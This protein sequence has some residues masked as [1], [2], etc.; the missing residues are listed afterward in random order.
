MYGACVGNLTLRAA[1]RVTVVTREA[2]MSMDTAKD[3]LKHDLG[4]LLYAEKQILKTLPKMIRQTSD[5]ELKERLQEHRTETEQHVENLEKAFEAMGLKPKAQKCPGILGIIEEKKDFEED[6]DPTAMVL[7][8]FNL[9]AGL[10]V[11]NYEI[12][13]YRSALALARSLAQREVAELLKANL[14]QEVAMARFIEGSSARVL[15]NVQAAMR[16]EELAGSAVAGK[17]GKSAGARRSGNSSRKK[18]G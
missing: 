1:P 13:A 5:A 4:D 17:A 3:L 14:D 2:E 9:G 12:A 10:R 8:A 6:E 11:E 7:E 18:A 15:R 16:E